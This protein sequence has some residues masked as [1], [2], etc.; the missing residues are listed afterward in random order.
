MRILYERID[1]LRPEFVVDDVLPFRIAPYSAG[2]D[3]WG[4]RNLSLPTRADIVA[5]GDSTTYGD[6]APATGS[7]PSWLA[8]ATGLTVYNLGLGGYGPPDYLYLLET[9]APR[10]APSLVIVGLYFGNDLYD[11]VEHVYA[12]E[13]WRE[14]RR[15]EPGGVT[16]VPLPLPPATPPSSARFTPEG[17]R[18]WLETHSMLFR[19]VEAGPVGQT[20]NRY[21]D[22]AGAEGGCALEGGSPFPT[23]LT[24]HDRLRALDLSSGKIQEGLQITLGLF[25]RMRRVADQTGARL[26]IVLIPTK[27]SVLADRIDDTRDA[28]CIDVLRQVVSNERQ[29]RER[30]I[31]ELRQQ[32]IGYVDVLPALKAGVEA[33][34]ERM[35]LRSG[36]SHP[37]DRGYRVIATT[38][39]PFAKR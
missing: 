30:I 16:P 6:A 22:R 18:D 20:I 10:L 32:G 11:A 13:H 29:A 17:A 26:L 28:A 19:L 7:W 12:R 3:E 25:A 14:L 37:N 34:T 21:A 24:P 5:I 38:V 9:L 8:R 4:F 2:H 1:F 23:V 35:Y 39:A 33:G 31:E 15:S 36:D 27:E